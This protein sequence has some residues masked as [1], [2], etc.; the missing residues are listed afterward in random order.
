MMMAHAY[1]SA[2]QLAFSDMGKL[3]NPN[4]GIICET[5]LFL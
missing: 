1:F 3:P 5:L 2:M 4:G